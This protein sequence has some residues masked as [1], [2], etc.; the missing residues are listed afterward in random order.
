MAERLVTSP[1]AGSADQ[2]TESRPAPRRRRRGWMALTLLL[3]LGGGAW[4][5]PW[6]VGSSDLKKSV[7]YA[8]MPWL[9]PGVEFES[10][11]L[12]WMSP[13]NLSRF[14][15]LDDQGRVLFRC[16][17]ITSRK[18]LWEMAMSPRS[19]GGWDLE[20]PE[21]FIRVGPQG[22]NLQPMLDRLKARK[23]RGRL[24]SLAV[25][26]SNGRVHVLDNEEQPL[27]EIEN[28]TLDYSNA[29]LNGRVEV[30]GLV[31]HAQAEG[32]LNLYGA[33]EQPTPDAVPSVLISGVLPHWPVASAAPWLTA[34][35]ELQSVSG[36]VSTELSLE[37]RPGEEGSS[38]VQGRI[39][40]TPEGIRYVR[41]R[42]PGEQ[43][44]ANDPLAAEVDGHWHAATD[45]ISLTQF[46][47]RAG[48]MGLSGEGVI[49]EPRGAC[50]VDLQAET[51]QDLSFLSEF[52][53]LNMQRQVV[54]EGLRLERWAVVGALRP[55]LI[56]SRS[57]EDRVR[58][59]A[60]AG[61][62]TWDRLSA[63]G[64]DAV[65]G[66][67]TAAWNG[68]RL[69]L[70]PDDVQ[71]SGGTL[72]ALPSIA[73]G[74]PP[75]VIASPGP[76]LTDAT[77]TPEQCR[78]WMRYLSPIMANATSAD[79]RFSLSVDSADMPLDSPE[80]IVAGGELQVHAARIGPGPLASQVLGAVASLSEM[81]QQRPLDRRG[82]ETWLELPEQSVRFDVREGRVHH[83][84]LRFQAGDVAILSSGSVGFDDTLDLRVSIPLPSSWLDRG[85]LLGSLRGE[86]VEI[87]VT[88]TL[89][90][91]RV[92]TRSL[93]ELGQRIGGKAA[94]G[95]LQ[96]L[97]D[98][99]R[100][101]A[102]ENG[103][104]TPFLQG[105]P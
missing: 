86:S 93:T 53:P 55:A 75:R 34:N 8:V 51:A 97:L 68:V 78:T 100:E 32:E 92:S 37:V 63:F 85:P 62:V 82:A 2:A 70:T 31:K 21:L 36:M 13:V 58:P 89:D 90:A 43:R 10:P 94:G 73:P 80:R 83:E 28:V 91:P 99:G 23:G 71:V 67:L 66:S 59:A 57:E 27:T 96:K 24:L 74:T 33:W 40:V 3:L 16:S 12:G 44:L 60:V 76:L 46:A 105:V 7:T 49:R 9:P 45:T 101:K 18:S 39:Q 30:N 56:G 52:L 84:A 61:V 102:A 72:V 25:G 29:G 5:L 4:L 69:S 48:E 15:L 11:S 98:R 50:I 6:F 22:T 19:P 20:D 26:F 88:G 65:P 77:L 54:S 79:G 95:L 17:H 87:Q 35:T 41:A 38:A 103:V 42:T 104:K 14:E 81:I 47:L 1:D 64:I